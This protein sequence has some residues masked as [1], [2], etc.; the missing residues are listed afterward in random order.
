MTGAAAG[1]AIETGE[2]NEMSA[3]NRAAAA[4]NPAPKQWSIPLGTTVGGEGGTFCVAFALWN[5]DK[6]RSRPLKGLV[7]TG[8]SCTRIPATVL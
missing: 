6:T 3:A 2:L 1:A 7:D 4:K 5:R 8:A